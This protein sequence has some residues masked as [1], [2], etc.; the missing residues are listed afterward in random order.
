MKHR[1]VVVLHAVRGL[2]IALH[3]AFSC[4]GCGVPGHELLAVL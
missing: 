2:P 1:R 3:A 4:A